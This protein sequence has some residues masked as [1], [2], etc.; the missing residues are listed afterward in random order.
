MRYEYKCDK[1]NTI[2]EVFHGM[3][4]SPDVL[5]DCD[6]QCVTYMKKVISKPAIKFNGS[7]FYIN[8]YKEVDKI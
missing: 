3:N 7:G 5:C 2:K 4:E 8:D 1:C 6:C